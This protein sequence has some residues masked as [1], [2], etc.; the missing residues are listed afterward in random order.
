[1]KMRS[2]ELSKKEAKESEPAIA[3]K[4]AGPRYPYGLEIRLENDSLE[5]LGIELPE[6]GSDV[7]IRAECC[8]V[9]VSSNERD[10]DKPTRLVTLQIERLA[11]NPAEPE[12]MEEAIEKGVREA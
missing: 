3:S 4:S 2:M 6:V 10:G 12:T 7:M 8:V 1:M 9:S 5:K 11:V